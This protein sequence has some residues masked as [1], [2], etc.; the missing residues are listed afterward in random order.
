M[1]IEVKFRSRLGLGLGR[2]AGD[3]LC[4]AGHALKDAVRELRAEA[5]AAALGLEAYLAKL[6]ALLAEGV[7]QERKRDVG[8]DRVGHKLVELVEVSLWWQ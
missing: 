6:E 1:V 5:P 2:G 3:R 8:R 4:W 7:R